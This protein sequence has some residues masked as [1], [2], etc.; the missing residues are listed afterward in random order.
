[1]PPALAGRFSTGPPGKSKTHFLTKIRGTDDES[2]IRGMGLFIVSKYL[3]W[4]VLAF[5]KKG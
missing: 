5:S 1:M 2:F 4:N 3:V